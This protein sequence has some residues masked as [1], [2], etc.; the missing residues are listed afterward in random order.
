MDNEKNNIFYRAGK[1][2]ASQKTVF[3]EGMRDGFPIGL[4]YFAVSFSLG[5]A[6]KAAGMTAFQG[7]IT[8]A[9]INASAGEYAGFQLIADSAP[10]LV[11]VLMIL[12]A[13][14]RYILMSCALSQRFSPKAKL[15]HRLLIGFFITDEYFG[16]TIARPGEIK[17]YYTYGAIFAG[18]P[19]WAVGTALGIIA[20]NML[21]MRLVSA[22]SVALYGMFL[23]VIIPPARKDGVLAGLVLACFAA[24]FAVSRLSVFGGISSGTKTI[25]L[26]VA[27]SALAAVLFPKKEAEEERK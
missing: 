22:L 4:G 2:F 20:G 3:L 16:I 11:T 1:R 9:L 26:T 23:A 13:N 15:H 27:V 10:Y 8:S 7:F 21:P 18:S 14:A 25:I 12:V 17:P 19:F 24:S 6:A 5:I